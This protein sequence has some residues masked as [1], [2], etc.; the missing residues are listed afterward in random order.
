MSSKLTFD[1][2]EPAQAG[3]GIFGLPFSL[4]ESKLVYLPVPWEVTTSYGGGTAQGP[5]AIFQA[6]K[7]LD[8]FDYEV[9]KPYEQGFHFLPI[10]E[11][12]LALNQEHKQL[13]SV[14]ETLD[15]PQAGHALSKI[16]KAS[17]K[18]NQWVKE[19][20][21]N[22]L[23][24]NKIVGLIGGEHSVPF[25]AFQA[26]AEHF[27]EF[28]ILHFDAHS[29]TR[30]QFMGFEH[31]HASIMHNALTQ[32]PNITKLTQVGIRDFCEEEVNFAHSQKNRVSIFFDQQIQNQKLTGTSFSII[33]ESIVQT[34][35]Q[36]VWI[37]FDIDGLNPSLC[38]NTGTP[39]PGG[40]SLDEALYILRSVVNSGR[41]LI[42]FDLVEVAPGK[43]SEWDANVGMRLLYK[44]SAYTL[45]SQRLCDWRT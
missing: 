41:T 8:L 18:L 2:N 27:G 34:L 39:V 29:D 25:G 35:P 21:L 12:I 32:I 11:S 43:D 26:A 3:S 19:E 9:H 31:S 15:S 42:G 20:T 6:S 16:N 30:N 13:S 40:L 23:R 10:Q 28:G 17:H 44:M 22:L 14:L 38:P 7:Q 37:S 1:P 33:S 36:K 24:K 4:D 45:V 5:E